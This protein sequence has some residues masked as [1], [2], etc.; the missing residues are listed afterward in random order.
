MLLIFVWKKNVIDICLKKN[1]IKYI[2]NWVKMFKLFNF[3][4]VSNLIVMLYV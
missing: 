1:C 2:S 3:F 4:F